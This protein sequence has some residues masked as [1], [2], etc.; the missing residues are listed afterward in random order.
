MATKPNDS[1]NM[2]NSGIRQDEYDRLEELH[3]DLFD[4]SD[5]LEGDQVHKFNQIEQR[6][7]QFQHDWRSGEGGQNRRT[8]DTL[9]SDMQRISQSLRERVGAGAEEEE[10]E[11]E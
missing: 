10:E 1:G 7:R 5:S 6:Y 11:E 2:G 3:Q 9:R 4:R 8:Y